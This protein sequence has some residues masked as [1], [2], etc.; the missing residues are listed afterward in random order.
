MKSI[1]ND[2][3]P[4]VRLKAGM[5]ALAKLA[6][7]GLVFTALALLSLAAAHPGTGWLATPAYNVYAYALTVSLLADGT[8]RL[9]GALRTSRGQSAGAVAAVYAISGI[10]AGLWLAHDQGTGWA[11]AALSGIG[12]LLLFRAAQLAGERIPGLLPVFALFVPLLVLLL[13]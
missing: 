1:M 4:S 2:D 8:L 6:A 3:I 11:V 13:F 5:Y 12:V 9:L 7:S 10:A